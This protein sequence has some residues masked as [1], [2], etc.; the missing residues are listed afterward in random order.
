MRRIEVP[1]P[2]VVV[3][4]GPAGVGKST[5]AARLFAPGETLS[6]DDLR[7]SIRG[8]PTDQSLTRVAFRILHRELAKRL[9]AG[10][11]VVVDATNLTRAARLSI[12]RSALPARAPVVGLVLVAPA[13][14]VR[15]RNAARPGR[16]VPADVV[17]RQLAAAAALGG[18]EAEIAALLRA[19]GFAAVHVI[20]ATDD[21]AAGEPITIGRV[22]QP[23]IRS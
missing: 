11:L 8:D 19:E 21:L 9:A 3:L 12:L 15:A 7:G 22:R 10:Q 23:P 13:A 20:A 6:S 1:V 2:G 18:D 5:L 16:A 17:D 4:V 14:T